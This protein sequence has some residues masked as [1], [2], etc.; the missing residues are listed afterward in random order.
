[1]AGLA[2][3][4][5]VMSSHRHLAAAMAAGFV[6]SRTAGVAGLHQAGREPSGLLS[7][8]SEGGFVPPAARAASRRAAV[9][10]R[11]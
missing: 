5:R 11:A 6:L 10:D 2:A 9:T 3:R 4:W 8:A 1:M 7:L